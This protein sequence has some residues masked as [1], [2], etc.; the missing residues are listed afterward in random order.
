MKPILT[1]DEAANQH[2]GRRVRV[3]FNLHTKKWSVQDAKTRLVLFHCTELFL[4]NVQGKISEA[5]RQRVLRENRKNVH[6]F[7]VGTIVPND[8]KCRYW[9]AIT[10][11]PYK[12]DSFVYHNDETRF[13]CADRAIFTE[14]GVY[15][16]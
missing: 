6:A 7:I 1:A 5:G 10:Y 4:D 8:Q 12:Y 3:Y 13:D 11:N 14:Q 16:S 9:K 15:V 2:A